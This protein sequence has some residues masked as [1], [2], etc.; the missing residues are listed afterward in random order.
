MSTFPISP[1]GGQPP[2]VSL[3]E[4]GSDTQHGLADGPELVEVDEQQHWSPRGGSAQGMQQAHGAPGGT[5][6]N[7]GNGTNP[8]NATPAGTSTNPG[9]GVPSPGGEGTGQRLAGP[10]SGADAAQKPGT[11]PGTGP[12]NTPGTGYSNMPGNGQGHGWNGHGNGWISPGPDS[13]FGIGLRQGLGNPAH[14]LIG[15]GG[16]LATP[17]A[18]LNATPQ[19]GLGNVLVH[20]TPIPLGAPASHLAQVPVQTTQEAKPSQ[21]PSTPT[22]VP[23]VPSNHTA[24][25]STTMPGAMPRPSA[26]TAHAATSPMSASHAAVSANPPVQAPATTIV[27][28]SGNAESPVGPANGARMANVDPAH[29]AAGRGQ[30]GAANDG[31]QATTAHN[32]GANSRQAGNAVQALAPSATVLTLMVA[33]QAGIAGEETHGVASSALF[34]EQGIDGRE[35]IRDILGRSYVFSADGKLVTRAQEHAGIGALDPALSKQIDHVSMANHGELS[36]HDLLFKVVAPAFAGMAALLGG[37]AAG[38]GVATGASGMGGS[39]LLLAASAMLGYGAARAVANLRE[40]SADG[41]SLDPRINRSAL[42]HWVAAGTQSAGSLT[43]LAL[44]L[45]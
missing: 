10:G 13:G 36:T 2:T 29:A 23:H 20:A 14:G 12:G 38:A 27:R 41:V 16:V 26:S 40:L 17:L 21:H 18:M 34:R 4:D 33:P 1:S 8:G 25:A 19:G 11:M 30:S 45:F 28:G 5:P 44:L 35:S 7:S 39:F 42:A 31:A 32:A 3:P 24:G 9:H 6:V 15:R 22:A 37:A 43:A